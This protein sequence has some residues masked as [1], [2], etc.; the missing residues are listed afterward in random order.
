MS[1]GEFMFRII[2]FGILGVCSG[3]FLIW[4][5]F[6]QID[7]RIDDAEAKARIAIEQL[8]HRQRQEFIRQHEQQPRR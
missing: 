3:M 1:N 2:F 5:Y 8:Q 7:R 4:F 6:G